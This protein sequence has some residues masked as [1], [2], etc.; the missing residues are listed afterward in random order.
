[1]AKTL[2]MVAIVAGVIAISFAIP[3]VGTAI[4]AS[5]GVSITA[6]TA[7]T[8]SAVAS[9]VSVAAGTA[10]QALMKPPP[11]QGTVSQVMIGSNMPIAY[12]MGRTYI[13]G[14]LIYDKSANGPDN[15][16][17]T[18][19]FA[20]TAAGPIEE[21]QALQADYTTINFSGADWNTSRVATGFY[22][23]DGGYLWLN[24]RKGLR[25]DTAL[26]AFAGR[27]AFSEWGAA[28]KLSGFAAA[29]VTMEFDEDGE[30]WASGIPQWGMIAKW[31]KIYDPRL[32]STYP[33]GSGTHRWA[34][35]STWEWSQNP[36]LH[37]LAYARGRFV[38][39]VKVVG[40]GLAQEAIDVAS[41][42][43][44]ANICEANVWYVGGAVYEA[45]GMSKWDNLK[46]ILAAGSAR[47]VWVGGVLS[48]SFDAPKTSLDTVTADDL[49][50]AGVEVMAMQSWRDRVNTIVPRYRSEAH[51]WEYVQA[52]AVTSATY[53]TEDGEEKT[54]EVQYDL[55]Q[56]VGQA[57][58]LAAYELVNGRE[59]GPIQ[60]TVKPRLMLYRPGEALTLN[61][62]DAGL[63]NELAVITSRTV[64]PANGSIQLTLMSET[65]AKHAFALG[66][67]GVAPPT[68]T[69]VSSE[70]ADTIVADLT[71][72]NASVDGP[73]ESTVFRYDYLGAAETGEFPRNLTFRLITPSGIATA[74]VAWEY[75]VLVGTVNT[76]TFAS[77]FQSMT[78]TGTGTLA[79][80]SLGTSQAAVEVKA[81]HFGVDWIKTFPLSSLIAA[82][83]VGG[84]GGGGGTTTIASKSSGFTSI[85]STTF[86]DITGTLNGM[87]PAGKTTAN[88]N[89]SLDFTPSITGG[90]DSWTVELKWQRN[91]ASVWTDQGTTQ[92][93]NSSV[94]DLGDGGGEVAS[95]AR[96]TNNTT[97]TGLTGGVAY[98]W[99]C[100][101]RLT[102]GTRTHAVTRSV[103]ITV[104]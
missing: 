4:G 49:A 92:S 78:G 62:P 66:V 68:P 44:L 2:K 13:G 6:A 87:M 53:V 3:G 98:D 63:D 46:R 37:A 83:P 77:G 50:D 32:D 102:S 70:E 42:V 75:R 26:T 79:V 97:S 91:I 69:I 76:F 90:V 36:A 73:V 103:S 93:A 30:R 82:A 54:K 101:A 27:A 20:Y 22:G 21:F 57:A 95:G 35:E 12:A 43:E 60:M 19:I 17:R 51:K 31:V 85:N 100:M 16:D 7:A 65:T 59:F 40:V 29:S 15:Y 39:G 52:E 56:L 81:T 41:F 55:V 25:P 11:M 74:D 14:N 80:S 94:I 61:I 33:G 88:L 67:T 58:E 34:D 86:T 28:Y 104:D 84:G 99:R 64:D 72:G 18:Q 5:I 71:K 23:A 47:P 96:V 89:A 1:M 48:C 8:I 45:P 38:E 10:A 9:A 24:T